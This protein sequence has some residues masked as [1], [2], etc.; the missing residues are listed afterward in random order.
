MRYSHLSRD[1][2]RETVNRASLIGTEPHKLPVDCLDGLTNGYQPDRPVR[3]YGLPRARDC[4]AALQQ[5]V[6]DIARYN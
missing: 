1:R 6:I 4:A 2:L 5:A 3:F